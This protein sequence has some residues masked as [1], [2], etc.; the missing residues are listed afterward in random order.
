M[1][2]T[3]DQQLVKRINRSVLLR[4]LRI[5]PNQSRAQ[6]AVNSGLTKS[7]VSLLVRELIDDGWLTEVD[8]GTSDEPTSLRSLGRPS[9]PLCI[10]GKSRGLIGVEIAVEALR[11]VVLSLIG[12]VLW[13]VEEPLRSAAPSAVCE[14]TARLV[15]RAHAHMLALSIHTSGLGIGV[16]GVFQE[17]TGRVEIAPNLGWRNLDFM[18]LIIDALAEAGLPTMPVYVR[19]EAD[20]ASL[21]EYEF[22]GTD[23]IHSLIFVN[24]A[25]GV[26]AGIVIND[27][28]YSG[29]HGMAG[30]IG[31][32][33]LQADGL[34][35][36][37]GRRGCVETLLG[38]RALAAYDDPARGG[39]YLGLVLHNLWITF[40]PELIVVGGYSCHKYP[41]I[42]RV[43]EETLAAYA[44]CAH[45]PGPKVR[46]A[47]Y[48][49][50]ASAV[51]AAALTMHQYLR[52]MYAA[53]YA[54][55]N[56]EIPH[57]RLMD[58]AA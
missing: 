28:L 52:P 30:E 13:D 45:I 15:A 36:S 44:Q 47:R 23:E 9:I 32:S 7:T 19:N 3:G 41:E 1:K 49:M 55:V 43:A 39:Q 26:G 40:N 14:Q 57:L 31:H 46:V 58:E 35:C 50:L 22:P 34:R 17:A 12:E 51:G 4:M 6:L 10:N 33:I 29:M 42:V 54:D 5:Q 53:S 16:P 24:C 2:T 18:P 56:A 11:V 21:S 27:R 37:C 8:I 38:A 20:T 25:T 48:G